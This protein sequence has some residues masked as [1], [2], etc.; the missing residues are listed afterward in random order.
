MV[1]GPLGRVS[2][3]GRTELPVALNVVRDEVAAH[4]SW[5]TPRAVHRI[6][7]GL[8]RLADNDG[9]QDG[10][11]KQGKPAPDRYARRLNQGVLGGA[12]LVGVG[13]VECGGLGLHNPNRPEP[14]L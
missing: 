8:T 14:D 7:G 2:T 5:V 11:S 9:S 6:R 13:H 1:D 12:P 10:S 4:G 3:A